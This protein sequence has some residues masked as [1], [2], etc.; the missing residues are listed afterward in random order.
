MIT[1]RTQLTQFSNHGARAHTS[2]HSQ[3]AGHLVHGLVNTGNSCFLNSVLQALASLDLLLPYLETLLE[4]SESLHIAEE[5]VQVTVA[6]ADTIQALQQPIPS[7]KAFRPRA[8]VDALGNFRRKANSNRN[9]HG[10]LMNREQQDAQELFQLIS[11][12][13][14]TEE[15]FV[16]KSDATRPALDSTFLKHLAG[17]L[18]KEEGIVSQC[19]ESR[20]V[21]PSFCKSLN[22]LSGLLA[23]RLSCMQCGY[24]EAI[25]HFTFDNL[26]LSLPSTNSCYLE[27][28]LQQYVNLESLHDVVCRKCS[29]QATLSRVKNDLLKIECFDRSPSPLQQEQYPRSAL[30]YSCRRRRRIETRLQRIS[31]DVEDDT[32]SSPSDTDEDDD[33]SSWGDDDDS[34]EVGAELAH[35]MKQDRLFGTNSNVEHLRATLIKQQM[36]LEQALKGDVE[37]PLPNI[38]ISNIVSRHCTKQV[39]L[40]RPPPVLC[41][42]FIRSHYSMYGTLSKNACHVRFPEYLDLSPFCTTGT[43]LT[44]PTLPISIPGQKLARM[45]LSQVPPHSDQMDISSRT[46]NKKKKKQKQQRPWK[47]EQPNDQSTAVHESDVRYI[48]RLQ[49]IVVHFGGHSYGHFIAYRRKPENLRS[50]V[51]T[52]PSGLGLL[53]AATETMGGYS[54]L[55]ISDETVEPVSINQALSANPYM[56]LY[57]RVI[58]PDQ[59]PTLQHQQAQTYRSPGSS[60]LAPSEARSQH[61][62]QAVGL[63]KRS[64][65]TELRND[66]QEAVFSPQRDKYRSQN[67][68]HADDCKREG[69]YHELPHPS[70][71][72]PQQ[73][74]RDGEDMSDME[75]LQSLDEDDSER[76][77]RW[78]SFVSSPNS[79]TPPSPD[80]GTSAC[81]SPASSSLTSPVMQQ[82]TQLER[83]LRKRLSRRDEGCEDG[84]DGEEMDTGNKDL[85]SRTVYGWAGDRCKEQAPQPW[86]EHT[87]KG[88]ETSEITALPASHLPSPSLESPC[89]SP[90][91]SSH[92]P[93]IPLADSDPSTL[94]P[95][96]TETS[97]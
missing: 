20:P 57:E 35:A 66:K 62:V 15:L 69:L 92:P 45:E 6:L 29:L 65:R 85:E 60:L 78:C 42:H 77:G 79:T 13:L 96:Y 93:R 91:L 86:G 87:R 26:S 5:E 56:L 68:R 36:M 53:D 39:M 50:Q 64:T 55:R 82:R 12:A 32:F 48:Y 40:A 46:K 80:T 71:K 11:T 54:W 76:Y 72:Q 21:L 84:D 1:S 94:T 67:G 74:D 4:H 2:V 24:T 51:E 59:K 41:L 58:L 75:C 44:Q 28:C 97:R 9:Y 23:S 47:Q 7:R 16:Q 43:L 17:I 10:N 70:A 19:Q 3:P 30:H 37:A 25:R 33:H 61:I 73:S 18:T 63:N 95:T 83:G 90:E 88:P 49:S 22:P 38:K 14:S 89:L 34:D 27:E 52:G 31:S 81:S 8:I